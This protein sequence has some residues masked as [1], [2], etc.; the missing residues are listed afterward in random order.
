MLLVGFRIE[1]L[2]KATK[3]FIKLLPDLRLRI[4]KVGLLIIVEG[5]F[6]ENLINFVDQSFRQRCGSATDN[7]VELGL[8]KLLV[9]LCQ[10]FEQLSFNKLRLFIKCL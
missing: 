2:S 3:V 7:V 1:I 6:L 4:R 10:R 5:S 8:Q 9:G